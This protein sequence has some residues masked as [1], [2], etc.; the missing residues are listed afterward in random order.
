MEESIAIVIP[1]RDEED[2]IAPCL[3]SVFAAM[4]RVRC[5]RC[6]IVVVDD[7]STDRTA[8]IAR[9]RLRDEAGLVV[10]RDGA[11]VGRARADGVA[12]ALAAPA[13]A[14]ASA[15]SI[16]LAFTD[17]DTV[18]PS[19]W[20]SHQLD[21]R[22]RGAD[23]V[24]GVVR[25]PAADRA[26]HAAYEA[27]YARGVW[28]HGHRHVHGANMG[29]TAAA[30]QSAGGF[31]SLR[32]G[33]DRDLWRRLAAMRFRL[34]SDPGLEVDGDVPARGR[35]PVDRVKRRIIT[36]GQLKQAPRRRVGRPSSRATRR[37]HRR[38]RSGRR[39]GAGHAP[40]G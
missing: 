32:V 15:S 20:L 26:A 7:G 36:T 35:D 8:A 14:P 23:A 2:G 13:P 21:W 33:E 17:A 3:D 38:R 5:R 4:S 28:R 6:V 1:A 25:L 40:S 10:S 12:H 29:M 39:A 11:N 27:T 22:A 19:D 30:Y 9:A 16:W 34:V 18:V 37:A 31:A 24:A